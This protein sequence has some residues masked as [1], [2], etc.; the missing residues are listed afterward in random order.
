MNKIYTLFEFKVLTAQLMEPRG[1]IPNSQGLSNN[2]YPEPN[3]SN[4]S[5]ELLFL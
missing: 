1:S 4:F 2:P 3:Q 5:H